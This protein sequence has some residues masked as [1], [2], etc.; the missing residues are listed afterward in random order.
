MDLSSDSNSDLDTSANPDYEGDFEA[1]S[2][3]SAPSDPNSDQESQTVNQ[4]EGSL[5]HRRSD[6]LRVIPQALE[7]YA[8]IPL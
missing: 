4:R 3:L 5:W 7:S 6:T 2:D 8:S 1:A